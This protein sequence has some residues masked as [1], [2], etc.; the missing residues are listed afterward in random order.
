MPAEGNSSAVPLHSWLGH[1]A[2]FGRVGGPSLFLV[3]G[4]LLDVPW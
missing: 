3:V 4:P 2:G 1:A